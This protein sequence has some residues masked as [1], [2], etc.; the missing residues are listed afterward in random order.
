[1]SV[2]HLLLDA[3]EL[4]SAEGDGVLNAERSSRAGGDCPQELV[5]IEVA[6]QATEVGSVCPE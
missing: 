1:M 5:R 2:L 3:L 4:N 6:A